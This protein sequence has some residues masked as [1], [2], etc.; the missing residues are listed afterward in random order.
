MKRKHT[1]Q[2]DVTY[3]DRKHPQWQVFCET[4][5]KD[6][7]EDIIEERY[8]RPDVKIQ[9]ALVDLVVP[10]LLVVP[11]RIDGPQSARLLIGE[12][13]QGS[14]LRLPDGRFEANGATSLLVDELHPSLVQRRFEQHLERVL[15]MEKHGSRSTIVV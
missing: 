14:L 10:M 9:K 12:F 3:R 15:E 8:R 6:T 13:D 4:V 2:R 1:T 11:H 7:K 5:R